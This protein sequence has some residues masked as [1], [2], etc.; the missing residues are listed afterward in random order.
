MDRRGYNGYTNYETW[1]VCLWIDNTEGD[2]RYWR[3]IAEEAL[4]SADG[5]RDQARTDLADLL[6]DALNEAAPS[7]EGLWADLLQGALSEVDW[8]EVAETRLPE[9]ESEV[10]HG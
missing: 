7:V 6:K 4:E 1:V 8:Y 3:E 2:Y 10:S 5:D 9:E